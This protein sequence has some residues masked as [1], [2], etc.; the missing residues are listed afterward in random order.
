MNKTAIKNF[1]VSARTKL[2]DAVEQKAYE[3]GITRD[4]IKQPET[5]EGGF[6]I[7][8]KFFK[9]YELEQRNKLIQKIEEKGFDQVMEEVAYTWFNRF[10]A[11]RFMEVNE[12]LPTGVRVLSSVQEGKHEPDAIAEVT[13]LADELDLN[14]DIVYRRQ[15]ESNTEDL[16]K[17]ILVKQ[18]NKL[19]EIMPMMFEQIQDYTE[20][21]LPDQL[22]AEGSVIR[23]LVSDIDEDDWKEQ[24]EIIGWLYQYYISEKKDKVFADLKKNKKITKENIPAATQLFTPKWIVKYMVENSLGR[25]WLESHPNE[26]LQQQW[27]YYLE[28][29]EQ[30]PEVQEQLEKLKNKELSPEDITVLDPC[31][32]SGHILVYAFD[33]LYSIYQQAG[34]A[35]R[36]IPQ[37]I[38]EKNLYGLDID[39]R[40]AQLAYFALMMKARSY[41]RRIFR[42]S[43]ELNVC[44]IQE[45]N[46]IPQEAIDYFVGDTLDR[47]E[48][49]YLIDMFKDAKE[50]GSILD[51]KAVDFEVLQKKIVQLH[52]F[53][54]NGE[55]SDVF[56]Y[57]H[58]DSLFKQIPSLIK[59]AKIM[60]KKFDVVL[61]NPPY[62]G[63]SN[64][65]NN[66]DGYIKKYYPASKLDLYTVFME[67]CIGYTKEGKLLSMITQHSWMFVVRF[68]KLRKKLLQYVS[69]NSMLH[70]GTRAFEEI[71][72]E[73]VQST[74]FVLS[75]KQNSNYYAN[76]IRLVN[77]ENAHL[78]EKEYFNK[79]NRFISNMDTFR[80]IPGLTFAYWV[81]HKILS[82]YEKKEFLGDHAKPRIG[83]VTGD[84]NRFL[85]LWHEVDINLLNF[86]AIDREELKT[87]L[88][89]WYPYQKGGTYRKWYGNI[90][91]VVN[92]EK[93][94]Y[95]II[96]DNSIN[97]RVRSHNYNL[98]FSFKEGI[99]WTKITSGDFAGR[100]SPKG[101]LFD[102]A[103]PICLVSEKEKLFYILG[104]LSSK[105]GSYFLKLTNPTMNYYPGD[106]ISI[107]VPSEIFQIEEIEE[108]V[109]ECITISKVEWESYET[110]WVFSKISFL[111][112]NFFE[113]KFSCAFQKWNNYTNEQF[114]KIKE[115]EERLNEIFIK[116][117]ELEGEIVSQVDEKEVT[118]RLADK[119]RDI[120]SFI[121]YAVGC[122]L[123]RYSLDQEGLVFAGGEFD[124]SKYTTF[125]ADID[126][127]IPITDDE[128]FE[129]DIVSRFIDFVRV[130]FSEETLEENL[131]FIAEALSKKANETSRQ[132]I[133]RYFLKDFYKDHV[134]T[135]Q[136]RPIYW[137]FDSG[138]NDGFKA[139]IYMH[140]YDVGAVA[141]VRTDYLHTLQ[142]KYEAEMVRL[143][144]LLESDVSAQEKTRAKKAKEKL[145][146]QLLECQQYD[147]VIAH[148]A[149]QKMAIDLDDG[150]KVN[151]AKFQDVEIPQGEGK[152]PLKANLLAKI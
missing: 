56:F 85:R 71:G 113:K 9:S 139:L 78:K 12:Y 51:V 123:G 96:N 36:D 15:D 87:S 45:S 67:K 50:F 122:M 151:Y 19:G 3:L 101:F 102:D 121:S 55:V 118:I 103:G 140:R 99:T 104:M 141:K 128:Y 147:Q 43:V 74:A 94:G 75:N 86:N 124:E 60:S 76:Y 53:Q 52:E 82:L 126:N 11:I 28:E 44:S 66:L 106:M 13:N 89:K 137:L 109:K 84:N 46:G 117:Y 26:E 77:F 24:V 135:Y 83:M 98:D 149:N 129:D 42:K 107:P 143:D 125:K 41:N 127:V 70:L 23:D 39:D 40:A 132:C 27:K 33:V 146:K 79:S 150:V 30:E 7:N 34:Y 2:I 35:E 131:D 64:M 111:N 21:L 37:L 62:M 134:R 130:T 145:Q 152:K 49:E 8:E 93:D 69:V 47:E 25:L 22:L 112:P 136:K 80:K 142:R 57:Q 14:V 65:N 100:Y 6:R 10:I 105:V 32:G 90:E 31:M 95:E 17:Y 68:E 72:G 20:L 108:I 58:E 133:R 115:K 116:I 92:W 138:K 4:E 16:F 1:A 61:T 148:V 110:S 18:C 144:V 38:L 48:V 91:Y 114:E 119:E 54:E 59:Q 5:Y 120:K 81:G 97:G 73:V 88:K 29:A 63:N